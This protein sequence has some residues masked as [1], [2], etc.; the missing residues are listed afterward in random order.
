[1]TRSPS[2]LTRVKALAAWAG[3]PAHEYC[4]TSDHRFDGPGRSE[5]LVLTDEEADTLVVEHIIDSLWAFRPEFLADETGLPVEAFAA[6]SDLCEGA[7]EPILA[8]VQATCGT[9]ILAA[10]A[11]SSDGR[12]HFLAQ[13]DGE[14]VELTHGLYAYRTN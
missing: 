9:N 6:L 8:M 13:Y 11:I 5:W 14:E 3:D 1:M 2:N 4:H 12:G 7:Q 10:S